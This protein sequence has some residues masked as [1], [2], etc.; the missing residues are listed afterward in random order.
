MLFEERIVLLRNEK[1]ISQY[2]AAKDLNVDRSRYCKW[3]QGKS[4]PSF[5]MLSQIADFFHVT[6]DYLLGRTDERKVYITENPPELADIDVTEVG[7]SSPF[8]DEQLVAL[9]EMFADMQ[10]GQ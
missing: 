10:K 7:Q 1:G 4:R 3:E 6:T 2:D 9:K 5:E 8:T